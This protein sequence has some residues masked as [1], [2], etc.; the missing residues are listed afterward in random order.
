MKLKFKISE[1]NEIKIL[2]RI[3]TCDTQK[4][5]D[6]KNNIENPVG[7]TENVVLSGNVYK[8]INLNTWE[9]QF[10]NSSYEICIRAY[11]LSRFYILRNLQK[12]N[13]DLFFSYLKKISSDIEFFVFNYEIFFE[14]FYINYSV[15]EWE[16]HFVSYNIGCLQR[17]IRKALIFFS[18][19]YGSIENAI[20][21]DYVNFLLHM[22]TILIEY[23]EYILEINHILYKFIV[24]KYQEDFK[25]AN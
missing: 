17:E 19:K 18:A 23:I 22:T 5:L 7:L 14:N 8:C 16:N 4:I 9:T 12:N 21:E 2:P 10:L 20:E 3:Y 6:S 25:L 11:V 1:I 15:S 13:N 24:D